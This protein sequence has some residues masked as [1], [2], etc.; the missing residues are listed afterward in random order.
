MSFYMKI[1][2]LLACIVANIFA[3]DHIF[4]RS[5][6]QAKREALQN[7]QKQ[8]NSLLC[9]WYSC[10]K[11]EEKVETVFQEEKRWHAQLVNRLKQE[12]CITCGILL[13]KTTAT[14]A[15]IP[16][17]CDGQFMS[18]HPIRYAICCIFS[19]ASGGV[20]ALI[21]NK[22]CDECQA[23]NKNKTRLN[24]CIEVEQLNIGVK[25]KKVE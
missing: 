22:W 20:D 11:D 14:C 8:R 15:V 10:F 23:Y 4:E 5:L 13:C 25:V 7:Y 9:G 3:M 12:K 19:L 1:I 17:I 21:I 16:F 6:E 24:E 18:D 2:L